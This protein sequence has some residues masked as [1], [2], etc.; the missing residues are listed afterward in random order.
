LFSSAD[1]E[2][3]FGETSERAKLL[4]VKRPLRG[5]VIALWAR[6]ARNEQRHNAER[7]RREAGDATVAAN[8]GGRREPSRGTAVSSK[9]ART[10]S[11]SRGEEGGGQ[12][13]EAQ[14]MTR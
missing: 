8:R 5:T 7:R 14:A 12:R 10:T 1:Q 2:L 13:L 3:Y 9:A 11:E 6:M 4:N